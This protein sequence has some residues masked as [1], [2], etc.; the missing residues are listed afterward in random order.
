MEL[1]DVSILFYEQILIDEK[2][3]F[4]DIINKLNVPYIDLV[5]SVYKNTSDDLSKS[6]ANYEELKSRLSDTPYIDDL[7]EVLVN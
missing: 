4:D 7:E 6:I 2:Q 3:F 5:T 1:Y